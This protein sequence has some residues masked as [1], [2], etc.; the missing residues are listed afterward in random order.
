MRSS[1][2]LIGNHCLDGN[3]LIGFFMGRIGLGSLQI[4]PAGCLCSLLAQEKNDSQHNNH[5]RHAGQY[6]GMLLGED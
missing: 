6:S 3:V 2:V 1:L 5:L 4:I